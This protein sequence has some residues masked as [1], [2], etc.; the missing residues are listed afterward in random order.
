M[1][2]SIL[3]RFSGAVLFTSEESE[4]LAAAV[5]AA[6][7]A[8]ANLYGA[9]LYGA[10]LRDADLY[11]AN[12]RGAEL[13]GADL[14]GADLY[15][16]NLRDAN[17]CDA[18]LCG[19]VLCGANLRDANLCGANLC[20]AN[21]RG[22]DLCDANLC[23]TNLCD[24]NLCDADLRSA[25]LCGTNLC[26]A[27]LYGANLRDANLRDAVLCGA[28]LC[29]A[30]LCGADMAPIRNDFWDVLIRARHEIAGLRL[31]L[32]E[33]RV[34]GS[35]YEGDCACLV[36]TIA[37][38]KHVEYKSMELLKPD[39]SRPIEQFFFGINKGDTPETSQHSKIVI[40]W[41]D[42]FQSLMEVK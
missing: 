36:G 14:Y 37:N 15:G 23:G 27:N 2:I 31:A 3:H 24:A 18:D 38:I 34:N 29:G 5:R 17:L 35:T 13:C 32:I 8:R 4:T 19:A 22:A 33:G 20:D 28:N 30:N 7:A 25:N 1:S 9:D 26:G 10:N 40:G 11:G 39:S 21:L 42:E 12:L 16:A 41:I 6:I